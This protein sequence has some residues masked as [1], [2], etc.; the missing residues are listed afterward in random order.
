VA[1]RRRHGYPAG[2]PRRRQRR[3]IERPHQR[4]LFWLAWWVICFGLWMLL[5]FKTERA[6]M[7]AGALAAAA[8]ATGVELVR[9]HGFAPFHPRLSWW[10]GL[11]RVPFDVLRETWA[12]IAL[13]ARHV[14]RGEPI[15]GHFR[16]V[17][18]EDCGGQDPRS[19]TRRAIAVWIGSVSPNT[20]VLG[21]DEKH[22]VAVIHQLVSTT[23]PPEPDPDV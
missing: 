14:A 20:Y 4:A 22:D 6:E 18:F 12:L 5:V 3:A 10:H 1:R 8:A 15:E 11:L 17:H 16:F 21:F 13:L 23:A 9:A 7:V 2:K 19:Q